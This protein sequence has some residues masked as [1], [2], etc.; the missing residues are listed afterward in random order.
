MYQTEF[1]YEFEN[2]FQISKG[3]AEL[4]FCSSIKV[5]APSNFVMVHH[6]IIEKEVSKVERVQVADA[7]KMLFEMDEDKRDRFLESRDDLKEKADKEKV[8]RDPKDI[9][10]ELMVHGLDL[11][12]AS[13]NLCKILVIG[14]NAA[15][16]D[17][18]FKMTEPVFKQMSIVDT[19]NILGLY[20]KHFLS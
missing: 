20:I 6:A 13:D 12:K 4:E 7:Q 8:D 10:K 1:D 17:G 3:G 5:F 9:L 11:S 2:P 19:K 15:L 18:T 14:N 16:I